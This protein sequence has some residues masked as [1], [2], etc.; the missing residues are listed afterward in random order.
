M[1]IQSGHF[2]TKDRFQVIYQEINAMQERALAILGT[3]H[4]AASNTALEDLHTSIR[5]I[6]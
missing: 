1:E 2:L 4:S 3:P 6:E 5:I